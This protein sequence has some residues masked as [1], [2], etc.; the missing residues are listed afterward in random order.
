MKKIAHPI[1]L[2]ILLIFINGCAGY[3]PIFASTKLQ[4]KISDYSIEGNKILGN[5]IYYKV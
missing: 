4:F 2:F 1:F 3:E 5:K